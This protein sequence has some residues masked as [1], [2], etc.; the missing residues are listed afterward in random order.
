MRQSRRNRLSVAGSILCLL[1][2]V[3]QFAGAAEAVEQ[4]RGG[5]A[6]KATVSGPG[7][8][9]ASP[10]PA[11][12]S[13]PSVPEDPGKRQRACRSMTPSRASSS[14]SSRTPMLGRTRPSRNAWRLGVVVPA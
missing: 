6:A 9:P 1:T 7:G 10:P 5:A 4:Q 8:S 3:P 11:V 12:G 14:N 13:A 2:L